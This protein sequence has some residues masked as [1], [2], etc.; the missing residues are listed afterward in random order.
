[1]GRRS[2]LHSAALSLENQYYLSIRFA[3]LVPVRTR[4]LNSRTL[5]EGNI[6]ATRRAKHN[7]GGSLSESE[8]VCPQKRVKKDARVVAGIHLLK[9]LGVTA[10]LRPTVP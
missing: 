4:L 8:H 9:V 7:V 6:K 3:Y 1:M 5:R 2:S 10:D